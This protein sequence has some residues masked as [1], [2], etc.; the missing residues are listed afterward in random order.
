MWLWRCTIYAAI[1]DIQICEILLADGVWRAQTHNCVKFRHN[2]RSIAEILRFLEFSRWP[3]PPS[4][5]FEM[6]KFYWSLRS[7]GLRRIFVPNF[8]KIGCEDIKIFRFFK[9]AAPSWIF[10]FVK[11]YWLAV[12]G[13]P[14]HIT[15][16]NFVTIGRYIAETLRFFGIFKMAAAAILD[17]WN[18]KILLV[19]RVQRVESHLRAKF[20][21]NRSIGCEVIKIFQFFKMAAVRHIGFIWDTFEPPTVSNCGSLSL[22]KIWLWSMQ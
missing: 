22:C 4:W 14:R 6:T 19:I 11:F 10:K 1:L 7:R 20:C 3:P 13:G 18:R 9:M 17:F 12:S 16:P 8:V 5:I 15:V 21:Q 2:R